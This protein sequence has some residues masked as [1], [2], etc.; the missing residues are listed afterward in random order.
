MG[1]ANRI[2]RE[3]GALRGVIHGPL[4]SKANS[5]QLFYVNAKKQVC[6]CSCH[7]RM[8]A[9]GLADLAAIAWCGPCAKTHQKRAIITKSAEALEFEETMRQA[10]VLSDVHTLLLE[11]EFELK[12]VVYQDSMRRDL[13]VELLCDTLQG[14]HVI[15]NDRSLW[16]KHSWR[17]LDKENPRVEFQ[18]RALGG[19]I[20]EQVDL[21][22]KAEER[23]PF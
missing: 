2:W 14:S 17:R 21:F 7:V 16:A 9:A 1:K 13:D 11:G 15:K 12:T 20:L 8:R 18:L 23:V 19:P 3:G 22:A 5:R 4:P 10:A 6:P